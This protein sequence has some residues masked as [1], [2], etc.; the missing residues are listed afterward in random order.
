MVE[1]EPTVVKKTE[2]IF[3]CSI[4][5]EVYIRYM[6]AADLKKRE[7]AMMLELRVLKA[8]DLPCLDLMLGMLAR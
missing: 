2:D 8:F 6:N 7:I 1:H 3:P 4:D 5:P